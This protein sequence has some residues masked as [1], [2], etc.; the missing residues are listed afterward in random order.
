M[1]AATQSDA[2]ASTL[3][4]A[5]LSGPHEEVD[6]AALER[7]EAWLL[8]MTTLADLEGGLSPNKPEKALNNALFADTTIAY[9]L[10]VNQPD[11]NARP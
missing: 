3:A 7:V 9:W 10:W 6:R 4:H 8:T 11:Q 2:Y 1:G 5:V